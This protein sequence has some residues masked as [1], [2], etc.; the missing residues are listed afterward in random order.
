MQTRSSLPCLWLAN[1]KGECGYLLGP[2]RFAVHTQA[3][4]SSRR[5]RRISSSRSMIASLAFAALAFSQAAAAGSPQSDA[6]H[7]KAEITIA[8]GESLT[9]AL[10]SGGRGPEMVVV[11]DGSFLMGCVSGRDCQAREL[12]VRE[13]EIERA[14]ALSRL[15]VTRAEFARFAEATGY[16]ATGSCMSRNHGLERRREAR[17]WRAPGF[18]QT[19]THPVA[20]VSWDDA[21]A[22]AEWLSSETG[23]DY[24]LPTEAEWEYAA[25]AGSSSRYAW[26]N[27]VGR[28]RANCATCESRWAGQTT[29]PAGAFAANAFGLHDMHGNVWEWVE[30]CPGNRDAGESPD[31]S[32]NPA[33]ACAARVLRGGSWS[34]LPEQVRSASRSWLAA[35]SRSF[36]LGFRVARDIA[37]ATLMGGLAP[38]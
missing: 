32:P 21:K 3:R 4:S 17:G 14:F 24:R 27:A 20:C 8:P 13:V 34:N 28:R 37:P 10:G 33:A 31:A 30:D 38:Q 1:D 9:D 11:P 26:G 18:R 22:Y 5:Y 7:D 25:R 19:D 6:V 12:P 36:N 29:A 35:E 2:A 15:E 16:L 23:Q